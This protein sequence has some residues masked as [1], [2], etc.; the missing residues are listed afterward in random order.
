MD[1]ELISAFEPF[2]E[3]GFI[4]VRFHYSYDRRR[5]IC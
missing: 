3:K 1:Q 2:R 5:N 4:T